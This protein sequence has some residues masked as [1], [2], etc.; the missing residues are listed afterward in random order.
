MTDE[1]APDLYLPLMSIITYVLLCGLCY[2]TA[3]KFD[4]EVLPDVFF[5]CFI[6]Q[7]LEVAVIRFGFYMMQS[8]VAILNLFSYTGYKYTGLCLN[9]IVGLFMKTFDLGARGYYITLLWTA[10]AASFFMLKTMA[11]SIS[12]VTSAAGPKRE[13]M[14][15]LF[16][17]SQFATMWFVSQT[18]F[19]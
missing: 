18:K 19:L 16:G 5:K 2:G 15:W 3:G 6:T 14:V 4:P 11:N 1:N 12:Q 8:P 17:G 7:I 9:M 13:L 10:S